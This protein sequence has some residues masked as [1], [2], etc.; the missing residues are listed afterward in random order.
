[1]FSFDSIYIS[2]NYFL[3]HFFSKLYTL[4]NLHF[5]SKLRLNYFFVIYFSATFILFRTLLSVYIL[6]IL[7]FYQFKPCLF[8]DFFFV[9]LYYIISSLFSLISCSISSI[10]LP[11][12]TY[13][14]IVLLLKLQNYKKIINLIQIKIY[15]QITSYLINTY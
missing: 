2:C 6:N 15:F 9:K 13:I 12:S 5:F 11:I 3:L 14:N 7:Q 10:N 8:F 4:S 1:M